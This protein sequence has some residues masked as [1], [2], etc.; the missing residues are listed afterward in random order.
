MT[1][2]RVITALVTDMTHKTVLTMSVNVE[3]MLREKH[4]NFMLISV[5][6]HADKNTDA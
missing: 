3:N 6:F 5:H 1:D 4:T 2:T